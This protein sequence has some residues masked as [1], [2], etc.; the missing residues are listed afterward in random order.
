MS[1]KLKGADR[2]QKWSSDEMEAINVE[3]SPKKV[4]KIERSPEQG[5]NKKN[6]SKSNSESDQA[7]KIINLSAIDNSSS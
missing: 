1:K 2:V 5:K 4:I 3:S 6:S 7:A